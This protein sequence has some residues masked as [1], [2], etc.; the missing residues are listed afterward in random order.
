MAYFFGQ[1]SIVCYNSSM[2]NWETMRKEALRMRKQGFSYSMISLKLGLSKSTLSNWLSTEPFQPNKAVLTRIQYGPIIAAQRRHNE[3]VKEIQRVRA[4]GKHEIGS[5]SNRDLWLLGLGLYIGEGYKSTEQIKIVNAD[6]A[7]IKLAVKWFK[8]ICRISDD[9]ITIAIHLYPDNNIEECK[10][11]WKHIT[12]LSYKN[13]RKTQIDRRIG[14]SVLKNRKLPYGTA[15]ITIRS[16]G[17]PEFGV[18][19]FRRITG[20]MERVLE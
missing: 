11:F 16:N 1:G 14:K 12:G 7:V 3:K 8:E 13:F 9:N 19:L 10:E 4:L 17:N 5:L 6:P 15:H 2:R 18:K 20:W